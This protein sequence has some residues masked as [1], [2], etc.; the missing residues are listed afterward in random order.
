MPTAERQQILVAESERMA[1]VELGQAALRYWIARLLEDVAAGFDVGAVSGIN[2]LSKCVR[3]GKGQAAR[4]AAL[5]FQMQAVVIGI[6]RRFLILN[7]A[8]ID[9]RPAGL[10][11]SWTRRSEVGRRKRD[12]VRVL[13]IRLQAETSTG[14]SGTLA[15]RVSPIEV[16]QVRNI[17]CSA[18]TADPWALNG[19]VDR[20]VG[21]HLLPEHSVTASHDCGTKH[22]I[23]KP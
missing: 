9:I 10:D 23:R 7:A 17:E 6:A 22:A 8:H 1:H 12:Q 14:G 5:S 16:R 13:E 11:W 18:N 4:K 21:A 3:S 20:R 15:Q 2:G 19:Y